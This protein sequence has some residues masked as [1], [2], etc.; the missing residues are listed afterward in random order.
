VGTISSVSKD[1]MHIKEPGGSGLFIWK[2]L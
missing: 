1:E 2:R